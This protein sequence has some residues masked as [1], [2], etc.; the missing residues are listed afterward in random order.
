MTRIFPIVEQ[1][2]RWY[3]PGARLRKSEEY[4]HVAAE[5]FSDYSISRT[6]GLSPPGPATATQTAPLLIN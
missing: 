3:E 4:K 5:R 2:V 1:S 6:G